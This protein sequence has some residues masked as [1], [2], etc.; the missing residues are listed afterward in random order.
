MP[1]KKKKKKKKSGGVGKR[2]VKKLVVRLKY[3][4]GPSK[5]KEKNSIY[6]I[7]LFCEC[8]PVTS[9]ML[10]TFSIQVKCFWFW[11]NCFTVTVNREAL[12]F[13]TSFAEIACELCNISVSK[14]A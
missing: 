8:A 11:A 3:Y 5:G 10:L 1:K 9:N 6:N 13:A 4:L 7:K 12:N 14:G 2:K